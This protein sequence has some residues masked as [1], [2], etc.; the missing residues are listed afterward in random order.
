MCI[1]RGRITKTT[2]MKRTRSSWA[3]V[4]MFLFL[5]VLTALFS[6]SCPWIQVSCLQWA[7]ACSSPVVLGVAPHFHGAQRRVGLI[8]P[9]RPPADR[10]PS[11]LISPKSDI[12]IKHKYEKHD[13]S[14]EEHTLNFKWVWW[15][16]SCSQ[17]PN[18]CAELSFWI[19]LHLLSLIS[20]GVSWMFT[21][22]C[23]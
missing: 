19:N 18:I 12:H 20:A 2:L 5:C 1:K 7:L 6:G 4:S 8:S 13:Y 15:D 22:H 14:Y 9:T 21:C 11:L 16:G 3:H 17:Q 10:R 23:N